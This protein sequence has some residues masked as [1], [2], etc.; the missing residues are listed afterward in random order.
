[1]Q[2]SLKHEDEIMD[3]TKSSWQNFN[4]ANPTWKTIWTPCL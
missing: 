3:L 1:M 4:R 2:T